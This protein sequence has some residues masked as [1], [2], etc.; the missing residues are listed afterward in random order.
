MRYKC[1]NEEKKTT[2][3][4]SKASSLVIKLIRQNELRKRLSDLF[5]HEKQF[6]QK[7][8]KPVC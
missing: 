4:M 2:Q 5:V 3:K 8:E 7:G 1:T 6:S